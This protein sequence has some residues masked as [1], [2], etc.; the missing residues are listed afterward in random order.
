MLHCIVLSS[1]EKVFPDKAPDCAGLSGFS[2]LRG[3]YGAFQIAVQSDVPQTVPVTVDSDLNIQCFHVDCIPAKLICHEGDD[4]YLRKTPG[5]YPDLLRPCSEFT[6]DETVQSLWFEIKAGAYAAGVHTVTV[7]LLEQT[8]TVQV[9]IIGADLPAQTMKCTHWFHTDCLHTWYGVPVFSA[10]YWRITE[11][12]VRAAAEHGVNVLYTPLFTPPLDTAEGKERP[13][14]QLVDVMWDGETYTFG[15]AKLRRWFQMGLRCG[16]RYFEM[17][18]LFT[19]WG[20][21]HAPKIMAQTSDGEKQIFGWKTWAASKKYTAFLTAF[22]EALNV[23]LKQEQMQDKYIFHVSDEPSRKRLRD[24][25]RRSALIRQLF[26][27]YPVI[28]ALSDFAFYRRGA[29]QTPVPAIDDI[30]PFF[31]NVPELWTYFCCGPENGGY[32]NRFFGMP[33]RRCRVL[34]FL[35]Y[36]YNVQGFLQW[37]L[38]FWYSQLSDHPINPF[39]TSDADGAFP[40]GDAYVLYPAED[41]DALISLRFKVFR[42]ALQDMRAM[43]LLEIYIGR[44]AV[45]RLFNAESWTM[46]EYPRSDMELLQLRETVNRAIA[47]AMKGDASK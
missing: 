14:V 7:H 5:L 11:N 43:Q 34:G 2:L 20:A 6:A 18:H 33:S 17:S 19:Q 41:G 38:N 8:C 29:V 26:P 13:T 32:P 3:E 44:D 30:E 27:D 15:F 36:R 10:E 46:Q 40:A 12:F 45:L 25:S 47:D 16:M 22:A 31:G 24:Y 23:F 1:L 37:G 42:D 21:M 39:Q 9:E 4:D 35:F 28:D